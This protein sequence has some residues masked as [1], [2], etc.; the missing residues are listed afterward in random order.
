MTELAAGSDPAS[1]L[2][3]IEVVSA[4]EGRCVARMKARAELI[5]GAGVVHGAMIFALADTAL[6]A[7]VESTGESGLT[8][9]AE[10]IFTAPAMDRDTLEATAT[11]V[12]RTGRTL[13]A[14]ATVRTKDTTVAEVRG[15]FRTSSRISGEL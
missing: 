12:S 7:A 1:A 14:D 15:V 9:T 13:V 4:R 11:V 2:L 8:S 3:G 6:A 5:N 10:I